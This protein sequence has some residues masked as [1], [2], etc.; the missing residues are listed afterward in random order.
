M[1]YRALGQVDLVLR[2]HT[3][4]H[5]QQVPGVIWWTAFRAEWQCDAM[6]REE[7][8]GPGKG[9]MGKERRE[10]GLFLPMSLGQEVP[11]TASQTLILQVPQNHSQDGPPL[12]L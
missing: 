1:T 4:A 11:G 5:R 8:P 10:R 12:T 3:G 7:S 2:Q 9:E 6:A